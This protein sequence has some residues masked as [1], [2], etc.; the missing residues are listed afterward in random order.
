VALAAL[1]FLGPAA[2]Q[3]QAPQA[4]GTSTHGIALQSK[5]RL[6][7]L[8]R[9]SL[10]PDAAS[11]PLDHD[12]GVVTNTDDANNATG[13]VSSEDLTKLGQVTA[14]ALD[15]NDRG[16]SAIDAGKGLI[17]VES[18]VRLYR[19]PAAA[20]HGFA[21]WKKDDGDA[22]RFQK[23]GIDITVKPL[24]VAAIGDATFA[25][26]GDERIVS[27]KPIYGTDVWFRAGRLLAS[28]SVSSADRGRAAALAVVLAGKLE[29]RLAAVVAGTITSTPVHLPGPLKAGPPP[30][31]PNLKSLTL[32]KAD[33]GSGKVEH[34]GY[35][36][37]EDI[38]PISEYERTF[39]G[40]G[41]FADVDETV[42]L[43]RSPTEAEFLAVYFGRFFTSES[44]L[45][46][47]GQGS[48]NDPHVTYTVK[49]ILGIKAG[50][51]L[52]VSRATARVGSR[53]LGLAFLVLRVGRTLETIVVDTPVGAQLVPKALGEL[54][55]SA[56]ARVHTGLGG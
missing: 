20:T 50:D 2:A 55:Q 46:S 22:S 21:F 7:P 38:A 29:T 45:N 9:T 25:Y 28:V 17:Q 30:G 26:Q 56:A 54:A 15:Y 32:T 52:V 37:D 41:Q 36:L 1:A 10:G 27:T 31:G 44:F 42:A 11:L 3:R 14:Y 12:S 24:H 39:S 51:Q 16:F 33:L 5:L 19:T 49:R 35:R 13:D 47:I 23:L 34:E 18:E 6:M 8:P 53:T 43:M 40:V 48:K 4:L